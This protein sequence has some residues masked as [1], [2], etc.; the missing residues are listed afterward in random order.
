M[1]IGT[2]VNF[3]LMAAYKSTNKCCFLIN[4]IRVPGMAK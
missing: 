2:D 4:N 1:F 3:T